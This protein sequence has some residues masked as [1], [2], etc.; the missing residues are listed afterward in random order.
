M[1]VCAYSVRKED[2][3]HFL[4]TA[5]DELGIEV[6]ITSLPPEP[7]TVKKAEGSACISILGTPMT[8]E[9]I[10]RFHS[11]GVSMISTRSVGYDHIDLEAAKQLGL[12][13]SHAS[14]PPGSVADYTLMLILAGLRHFNTILR[15]SEIGD[16]TLPGL[17]GRELSGLTVGVV[18]TGHIGAAVVQRLTG[19]GC[20]I[21]AFDGKPSASVSKVASYVDF[22]KLLKESDVISLHIPATGGNRHL[23]DRKAIEGM[24]DGVLLINTARGSIVDTDA[25]IK[26]LE[27]GKVA[28][29][30]LDTLEGEGA[31]FYHDFR[32]KSAG[33]PELA[34]LKDMPN[35]IM[36]PHV[37]FY[38]DS[39]VEEMARSSLK[40]CLL[41]SQGKANPWKVV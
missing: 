30:C 6:S 4:R 23:I 13:V 14:Y 22:P 39:A 40:S 24:K 10:G 9:L 16:Y 11:I 7:A 20:R 17:C 35:V 25:L 19:F 32:M 36:T 15:R 33:L 5:A 41:E 38:T 28:G 8:A 27:S 1:K 2:E 37:A 21:L 26:N 34:I 12:S 31:V 3:D 29:A 18:G